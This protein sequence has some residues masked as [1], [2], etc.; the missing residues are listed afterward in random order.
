MHPRRCQLA[1]R[2]LAGV[3][4]GVSL[5]GLVHYAG[6]GVVGTLTGLLPGLTGGVLAAWIGELRFPVNG[7]TIA[8]HLDRTLP[9]ME[10][11]AGLLVE[12]PD[13]LLG[14]CPECRAWFL[15]DISSGVMVRL[16]DRAAL[17][18]I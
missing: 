12:S 15:V 1:P 8:R 9:E 2:L 10:E 6:G 13:R 4:G 18:E 14:I 17:Q 11:S 5:A 16:P 7:H 3:A